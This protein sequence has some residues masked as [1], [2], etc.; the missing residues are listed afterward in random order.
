[1]GELLVSIIMPTY[2][3]EKT[4]ETSLKSIRNQSINQKQV[5]IIVVDGGSSDK[6]LE[7]ARRYNTRV[8]FN[9]KRLPE[10][11]KQKGMLCAEGKYGVF[12]DSDESFL[13]KE[14][15]QKRVDLFANHLDVKNLVSTGQV[16]KNGE[17]G[18]NRYANFIGDPFSNFVYRYNG[19][20]RLEDIS[21]QY[22]CT[23][24]GAGLKIQFDKTD[25]LPLFDALGNMFEIE[26]AIALYEKTEKKENF[27]ANIF[28]NMVNKTKSA[29]I[30]K[31]DFI[32]HQ[33]RLEKKV[34]LSKIRW[35]IK[36]NLFQNSGVGYTARKEISKKLS[37]RQYLFIPYCIFIFPVLID[38]IM[39]SIKNK[40]IYFVWHIF[41][42]EYTLFFIIFYMFLKVIH[43]PVKMD[44]NYGK[45]E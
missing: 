21:R 41:Y 5:E 44:E 28:T 33:P 39:L 43:Y 8:I 24:I 7:I 13:N 23:D 16:C 37:R 22:I 40:D 18:I 6:T 29:I 17:I 4:I 42:A 31:D 35:R 19:Y 10:F 32:C 26:T 30:M 45:S 36:N 20:N 27:V 38:S 25:V 1:M 3:S 14:S 2:N 9:E 11:A 34:Y 15:L 12:L